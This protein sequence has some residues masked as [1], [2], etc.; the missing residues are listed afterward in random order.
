MIDGMT[1][2][3]AAYYR[4]SIGRAGISRQRATTTAHVERLGGRLV[5][6]DGYVDTDRTAYAPPGEAPPERPNYR[7]MVAALEADPSLRLAA[8]HADRIARSVEDAE[9]LIHIAARRRGLIIETVRGGTYDLSTATGRKRFR[10]DIIDATYEVDHA[11]ERILAQQAEL[12]AE[13]RWGGGR[14][15]FGWRVDSGAPGGLVLH[16]GEAA[17]IRVAVGSVLSGISLSGIAREW[18]SIGTKGAAGR[19][20]THVTV[21]QVLL[22]PLNAALVSL[23]GEVV[24]EGRWPG[25]I[26]EDEWRACVA[27][28]NSPSRRVTPGPERKHLLSGIAL[29][30]GCG[31]TLA[32][33]SSSSALTYVC[34]ARKL[35]H[36]AG[37]HASRSIDRLDAF[38]EA[39]VIGRLRREDAAGLLQPEQQAGRTVI[40]ERQGWLDARWDEIWGLY[41]KQVL[42]A[43]EVYDARRQIDAERKELRGKLDELDRADALAPFLADPKDAWEES[44]IHARRAVVSA[45]LYL[46]VFPARKGRPAGVR[47]GEPYFDA[48]SIDFR[49]VQRLPSDG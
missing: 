21:R 24:G 38:V 42:T 8:W 32:V 6:A 37:R 28:L 30:G 17:L 31:S 9:E 3:Y 19:Q 44:E 47:R 27:L 18:N 26:D 41:Q 11:V 20:W 46:T 45:L 49:W 1:D 33:G 7:K 23:R 25:V 48:G 5:P 10:G 22:R 14:P 40:T 39:I 36:A 34:R 2:E 12:R 35:G 16:E 43:R 13:G 29:C 15:P 4:K